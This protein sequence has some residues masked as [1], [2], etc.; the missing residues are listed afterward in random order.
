MPLGKVTSKGQTTIPK[1][2]REHFNLR[3]GDMLV[4]SIDGDRVILSAKNKSIMDLKGLLRRPGQRKVS[5]KQMDEAIA[6]AAAD[7]DRSRHKSSRP[8]HRS[9]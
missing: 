1:E 7:Y 5:L 6:E 3:P 2:V 8:A 9:R 4:Y